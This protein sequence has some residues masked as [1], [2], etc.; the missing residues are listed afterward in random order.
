[1]AKILVVEDRDSLRR[2]LTRAL[3]QEGHAVTAAADGEQ[4]MEGLGGEPFD[5]V[6][7]DLKLPGASG[8]DVLEASRSRQPTAPVVVMTGY[9]TVEAAVSA[10]KLGAIDFL[11]KPVDLDDLFALVRSLVGGDGE[12]FSLS[13]VGGPTI[14]GRHPRTRAALRLAEKVAP[15][16]S[17]VLLTGESG[18]GKEVFSRAIHALSPRR[19]GPFVAVNCAA[20]PEALLEN[21]L[22]GHEKGAFTGAHKRQTGR[23]EQAQTGTLLLDEVG[24]LGAAVQS[25][26]LR[27]LDE[28]TFERVGGGQTLKADVRLIAATNRSLE[29]MVEA[30]EFRSDLFFRLEV[31]PIE[32]PPLRDRAT[33]IPLLARHLM[34]SI[35][36]R[37]GREPLRLSADAEEVLETQP[38]PGN[39]RQLGNLLERAF[40]LAEG[41]SLG[42]PELRA[43]VS[44]GGRRDQVE[45]LR[46]ALRETDGDK[47]KAASLLGVSYSTLLRRVKEHDLDGYPKYRS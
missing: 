46:Q 3:E 7:T 36:K 4:A 37:H 17:T 2:M 28:R 5:L 40:I 14:V 21:E 27:V 18:T 16:E 12:S 22:F 31:F 25:K 11:E 45:Q 44:Q 24:E 10:M 15:T 30:G 20:I 41:T 6:L 47:K 33:D 42:G 39:V 26:V 1:M 29:A 35:A 43:L 23:F 9:G 13:P 8:L 32:L 19:S 38:W 34:A